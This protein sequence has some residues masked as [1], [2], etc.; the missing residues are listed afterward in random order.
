MPVESGE[1]LTDISVG[2]AHRNDEALAAVVTQNDTA[3]P[4]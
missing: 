3:N 4:M 2:V 1:V